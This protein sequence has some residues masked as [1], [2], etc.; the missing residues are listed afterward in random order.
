M[1]GLNDAM[2]PCVRALPAGASVK[3]C[4]SIVQGV[5]HPSHISSTRGTCM[6]HATRPQCYIITLVRKC[7]SMHRQLSVSINTTISLSW[8]PH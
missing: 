8:Q 1:K 3:Q 2:A 4:C 6:Q 5:S 7:C